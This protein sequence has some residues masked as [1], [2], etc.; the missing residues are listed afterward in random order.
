MANTSLSF[1]KRMKNDEFYTRYE[2]IERELPNYRQYFNDKIIYLNCDN[3]SYSAFYGYFVNMFKELN[4]KEL[5]ATFLASDGTNGILTKYDGAKTIHTKLSGN[6]DF[7]SEECVEFLSQAD[8]IV[9]NPPFSKFLE[10]FNL[11]VSHKKD[12]IIIGNSNSIF[13]RDVFPLFKNGTISCGMNRPKWFRVPDD[14]DA[15]NI[16][17]IEN[18]RYASFGNICWYTTFDA[19]HNEVPIPLTHSYSADTYPKY[20]NYNAIEVSKISMIPK[21]YF[22]IM[23]VPITYIEHHCPKQ[24]EILWQASGNTRVSCPKDILNEIGYIP[25]KEDRGGAALINGKR[26]YSRVLIRRIEDSEYSG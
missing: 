6:G 24:F 22:G 19:P 17:I 5:W 12:F 13:C 8:V 4:L 15:K 1:S 9:T 3:P 16:K 20:D 7:H 11:L 10:F 23:G 14:Y 18:V 25:M 21:D 2:D 26:K